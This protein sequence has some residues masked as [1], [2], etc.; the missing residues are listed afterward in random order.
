V[1]GITDQRAID[2]DKVEISIYSVVNL[3]VIE[4][5]LAYVGI[6]RGVVNEGGGG[7]EIAKV[8]TY[9]DDNEGRKVDEADTRTTF[10]RS[11]RLSV[12]AFTS[13]RRR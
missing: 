10:N 13:Q 2:L 8:T 4:Q 11:Q 6:P 12:G 5:Y 9:I 1:I 3:L 7:G